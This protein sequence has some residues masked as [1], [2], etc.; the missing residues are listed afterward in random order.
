MLAQP[1]PQIA[2]TLPARKQ[3]QRRL[4]PEQSLL[5]RSPGGPLL[6]QAAPNAA[7]QR[8]LQ[9]VQELQLFV[10]QWARVDAGKALRQLPRRVLLL[11]EPLPDQLAEI[12]RAVGHERPAG[13]RPFGY[14]LRPGAGSAAPRV[15]DQFP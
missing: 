12:L 14:D 4:Q 10:E 15:A 6:A 8:G 1:A 5:H 7:H 3:E 13:K 9:I 11:A 2:Q